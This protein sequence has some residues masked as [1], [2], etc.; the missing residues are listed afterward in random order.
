MAKNKGKVENLKPFNT[1]PVEKQRE[2]RV[3]GGK[4]SVEVRK[5]KKLISQIYADMMAKTYKVE[6]EDGEKTFTGQELLEDTLKRVLSSGGSPA[7]SMMKEIREATE[8]SK[9]ALS[10]EDGNP[11]S[12]QVNF[13]KPK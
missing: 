7:V 6:Y 4:K 8:G 1:L 13:V 10:G 9:V 12:I 11:L 2:I 5:E 3:K